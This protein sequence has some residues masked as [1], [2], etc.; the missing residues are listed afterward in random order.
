MGKKITTASPRRG[1]TAPKG[2]LAAG[3]HC[4]IKKPGLLDLALI[5]SEQSGPIA[6]VFTKNQV[7][8]APV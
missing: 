7:V 5:V 6:G 3:I 4:G 8:A 1:V 2:F